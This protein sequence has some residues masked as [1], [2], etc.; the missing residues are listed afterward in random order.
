MSLLTNLALRP[1][2]HAPDTSWHE[3]YII[4]QRTNSQLMY[5]LFEISNMKTL[6]TK[7]AISPRHFQL[8]IMLCSQHV[9]AVTV[10]LEHRNN[11]LFL[12]SKACFY[13]RLSCVI[14]HICLFSFDSISFHASPP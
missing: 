3:K 14:V 2:H 8:Q 11:R 1:V 5:E 6:L 10:G 9:L 12:S 13:A 7:K 4:I